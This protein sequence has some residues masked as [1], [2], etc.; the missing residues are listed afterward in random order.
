VHRT[1]VTSL[2]EMH[3]LARRWPGVTV[4]FVAD[5]TSIAGIPP[6]N[7]YASPSLIHQ[8]LLSGHQYVPYTS[9]LLAQLITIAALGRA[10]W[11]VFLRRRE[12]DYEREEKLR[13]GM[14][15]G[16]VGLGGFYVLFGVLPQHVLDQF[17]APAAGS[18]L[19]A[20]AYSQ[21]VMAGSGTLPKLS[22]PFGYG[23]VAELVITAFSLVLAALTACAYLRHREPT[24]VRLLRA[25]HNGSAN[26]YV[27][28]AVAG[29]VALVAALHLAWQDRDR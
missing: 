28:Y 12:G 14:L 2:R 27:A 24:A 10:A 11:L 21:I 18:M 5:A 6:C 20:A 16:L 26:D 19:N 23:D 15:T 22:V 8:G 9:M 4:A 7:G 17:M 13:P 1:G 25:A 3:G 29:M